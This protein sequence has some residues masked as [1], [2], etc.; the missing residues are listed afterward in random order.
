MASMNPYLM[1]NGNCREAME[2]YKSCLGG[3]LT[4]ST[5]GEAPGSE[6][7]PKEMHNNIMHAMLVS[8]KITLMASDMM[9]LESGYLMGNTVALCVVCDS[10]EE[11]DS[12]FA[13]FSEGGK[14]EQPLVDT[15]FGRYGHL[16]DKFGFRWMFQQGEGE[17]K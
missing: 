6:D 16:N 17:K 2:F 15:F 5:M 1:F 12:L 13:K 11:I 10:R 4:M 3:E 14:V 8:G 9:D 7:L